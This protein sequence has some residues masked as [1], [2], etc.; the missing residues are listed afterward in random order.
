MLIALLAHA[1]VSA[2]GC[3]V[4]DAHYLLRRHPDFSAEFHNVA[5]SPD[6]PSGVA[7]AVHS[8]KTGLTTWWLPWTGGT[9]NLQNLASTTDVTA[10]DWRPP[11]PDGGPRPMGNREYL[12]ADEGY[13]VLSDLPR[14]GGIAPAHMLIPNAG[15]SQDQAFPAKQ[16]FD[17]VSCSPR[18]DRR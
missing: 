9:D 13:N 11:S 4:Q 6:W 14:R 15:S 7:L 3:P 18:S 16:F 8:G 2:G 10:R 5:A 1:A 12:G 17:L